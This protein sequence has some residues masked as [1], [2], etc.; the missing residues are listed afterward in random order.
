MGRKPHVLQLLRMLFVAETTAVVG[1]D[2]AKR[3]FVVW[4]SGSLSKARSYSNDSTGVSQF[5]EYL[6][7]VCGGGE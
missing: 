3:R 1:I 2:I 5:A 4:S 6:D 7:S